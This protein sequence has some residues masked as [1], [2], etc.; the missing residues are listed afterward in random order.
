MEEEQTHAPSPRM[1]LCRGIYCR[2]RGSGRIR[3]LLKR[4]ARE[5]AFTLLTVPC[6][7]L[8][9]QAPVLVLYPRGEWYGRLTLDGVRELLGGGSLDHCL[10]YRMGN[11]QK[12][13]ALK[14]FTEN[15]E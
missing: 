10:V 15:P 8:C 12:K 4:Q 3:R 7:R 5:R 6:F 13:S 1:V 9:G 11:L 2:R 14:S